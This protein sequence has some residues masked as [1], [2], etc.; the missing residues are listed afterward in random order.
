M[1]SVISTWILFQ[2]ILLCFNFSDIN[3]NKSVT[4]DKIVKFGLN[5]DNYIL[6]YKKLILIVP[7]LNVIRGMPARVIKSSNIDRTHLSPVSINRI[8]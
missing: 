5:L 7:D 1:L 6:F 2:D 3:K 4:F 8:G